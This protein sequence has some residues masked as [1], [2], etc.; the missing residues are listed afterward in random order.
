MISGLNLIMLLYKLLDPFSAYLV[1]HILV[2]STA[3]F[4]MYLFCCNYLL[5]DEIKNAN[6]IF[7]CFGVSLAF[8]I[9]PFYDMYGLSIAGQ[10]LL[11]YSFLNLLNDKGKLFDFW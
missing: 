10:P 2:H 4:G 11:L 9:L 6:H 5:M 8:G 7:I 1:N 3:F